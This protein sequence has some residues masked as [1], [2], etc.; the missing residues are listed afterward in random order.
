MQEIPDQIYETERIIVRVLILS[1]FTINS[2][3]TFTN[4]ILI[5]KFDLNLP[6]GYFGDVLLLCHMLA[7]NLNLPGAL[8]EFNQQVIGALTLNFGQIAYRSDYQK[9]SELDKLK[10]GLVDVGYR[11]ISTI[12]NIKSTIFAFFILTKLLLI[13]SS[14]ILYFAKN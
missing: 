12:G 10:P 13:L 7:T 9:P 3:L 14:I 4:I 11:F 1:F 2:L 6:P 8:K 5:K